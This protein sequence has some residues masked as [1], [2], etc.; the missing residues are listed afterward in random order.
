MINH[1]KY[2]FLP[3]IFLC[4]SIFFIFSAIGMIRD[5]IPLKPQNRAMLDTVAKLKKE[6]VILNKFSSQPAVSIG[7]SYQ[8]LQQEVK[9]YSSLH[10]MKYTVKLHRQ[11]DYS[12][13]DNYIARSQIPGVKKLDVDITLRTAVD[14]WQMASLLE[15]LFRKFPLEFSAALTADPFKKKRSGPLV[16]YLTDE[17]EGVLECAVTLY[18]I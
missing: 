4:L 16:M 15:S 14:H 5:S 12:S 10:D 8:A 11:A 17:Q 2:H 1:D 7:E 13:A 9:R 6:L 3:V 18:G